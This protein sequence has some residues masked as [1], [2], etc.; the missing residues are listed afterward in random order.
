MGDLAFVCVVAVIGTV[1]IVAIVFGQKF[2]GAVSPQNG[3]NITSE[4]SEPS[5]PSR[6]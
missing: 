6:S 2:K 3:V 5:D 1:G 4:P